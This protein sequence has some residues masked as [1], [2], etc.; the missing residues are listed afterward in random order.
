MHCANE[1]PC[2]AHSFD[3]GPLTIG[4]RIIDL[5]KQ[6]LYNAVVVLGTVK[7]CAHV[8]KQR[9]VLQLLQ[10]ALMKLH[11]TLWR[12]RGI[13]SSLEGQAEKLVVQLPRTSRAC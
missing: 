4:G 6:R 10:D 8:F 11:S 13:L 2:A 7:P 9:P 1:H 12:E 5:E 3:Q